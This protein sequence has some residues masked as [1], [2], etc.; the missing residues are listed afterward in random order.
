VSREGAKILTARPRAL[1]SLSKK[2]Q[3]ET[4]HIQPT[5]FVGFLKCRLKVM[6]LNLKIEI[7][8]LYHPPLFLYIILKTSP[9]T[10]TV[11]V[12]SKEIWS[13]SS[14]NLSLREHG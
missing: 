9:L 12:V 6:S 5:N 11:I 13:C 8:L 4:A 14:C 1:D 10:I 7:A 2:V 3:P